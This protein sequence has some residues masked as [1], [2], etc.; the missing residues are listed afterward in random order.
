[1]AHKRSS[2]RA[3]SSNSRSLPRLTTTEQLVA[4]Q[5]LLTVLLAAQTGSLDRRFLPVDHQKTLFASPT[6]ELTLLATLVALAGQLPHFFRHD[7]LHH[8]QPGLPHQVPDAVLQRGGDFLEWQHQLQRLFALLGVS[9]ECPD[10]S[11][12]VDLIS[13]LHSNSPF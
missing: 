4:A 6:V 3:H 13:F 12:A 2:S 5:R 1:M 7:Q 10:R 9:L 8:P 11:L